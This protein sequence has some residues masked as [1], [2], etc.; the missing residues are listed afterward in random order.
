MIGV[1]IFSLLSGIGFALTFVQSV[2][3]IKIIHEPK[4]V[5]D[6]L[7]L[8]KAMFVLVF[9][10]AFTMQGIAYTFAYASGY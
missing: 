7:L 1:I 8:I 3:V 5:N 2:A 9:L 6:K 10:F 4:Y